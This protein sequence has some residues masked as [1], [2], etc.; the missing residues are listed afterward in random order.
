MS[1][2]AEAPV[3]D[4]IAEF[5]R[6]G[7]LSFAPPGHK[8]GRVVDPQAREVLGAAAFGADMVP[9]G[10]FDDRQQRGAVLKRAERLM[11]EAVGA[12]QAFF[13]TCGSSLSV[14]SALISVAGPGE[15][16]LVNR[17]AHKSVISALIIAGIRPVWVRPRYDRER[18][19]AF[20]PEV[21][22]VERALRRAPEARGLLLASP[23][24]Y[25]TCADI[26]S[27]V[28][29]CHRHDRTVVVDEAWGAVFPF[30]DALPQWA[31]N[32]G[33]DLCVTSVHKTGGGLE[34]S[35]VFHLRGDRIAPEV[36]Q[37]R[38]D[39]LSTTSPSSLIFAALDGWRRQMVAEGRKLLDASLNLAEDTAARIER[40]GGLHVNGDELVGP[41]AAHDR[42]RHKI[43][44]DVA[45]LGI[46][47]YQA[48]D[49]LFA[50]R[51]IGLGVADH[52]R[53]AAQL[54]YA[55]DAESARALVEALQALAAAAAQLPR[56]EPIQ[57]PEPDEL[58]LET[59]MVPR[60]AFFARTEHVRL[61]DAVGRVSAEMLTPYPP[62]VPAIMPGETFNVAVLE[63]LRS[64]LAAGMTVPDAADSSL[65]TVRVVS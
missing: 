41:G 22:E 32:V 5:H 42:D 8:H 50:E 51:A 29:V 14:K 37:Q 30:H 24:D 45:G 16:M 43:I 9:S 34:Q 33:A 44:I 36:L 53:I 57:L 25:G 31:M 2:Q 46:S 60:D 54:S 13:S 27:I 3:L 58:T 62:G 39:I 23:T 19:L 12:D 6:R 4:G 59:A 48:S 1:N 20:P 63:Y 26:E 61:H 52:R 64:G 49:W 11:A 55:D 18:H 40:I 15:A 47:G 35:S 10:G 28:E 17:D 7:G 38:M 56:P 65:D 21:A